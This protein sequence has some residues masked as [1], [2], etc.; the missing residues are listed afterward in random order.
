[1]CQSAKKQVFLTGAAL[2]ATSV[3]YSFFRYCYDQFIYGSIPEIRLRCEGNFSNAQELVIFVHGFP[4]FGYIW[5]SQVEALS[6]K[7]YCCITLE[8]PNFH[9]DRIQNPWGYDIFAV[10]DAIGEQIAMLTE[11][12]EKKCYLVAHGMYLRHKGTSTMP[13]WLTR[14]FLEI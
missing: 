3:A 4:D 8:L 1:M 9:K 13:F 10:V 5:E 11:E 6:E 14:K 12:G 7:G 2:T